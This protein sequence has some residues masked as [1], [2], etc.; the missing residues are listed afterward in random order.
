[1][2]TMSDVT[3][4]LELVRVHLD[5]A[6]TRIMTSVVPLIVIVHLLMN[7]MLF[8]MRRIMTK[9]IEKE[10]V[11]EIDGG[12]TW[13]TGRGWV[14]VMDEISSPRSSSRS[15]S[16]HFREVLYIHPLCR[17]AVIILSASH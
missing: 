7:Y 11:R 6:N 2:M 16:Y 15:M 12:G 5:P 8:D 1:M 4:E 3:V 17:S 14:P 10:N 9:W 13:T